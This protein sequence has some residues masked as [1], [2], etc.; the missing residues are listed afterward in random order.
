MYSLVRAYCESSVWIQL[1]NYVYVPC[2][3]EYH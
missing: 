3:I 1:G 2:I